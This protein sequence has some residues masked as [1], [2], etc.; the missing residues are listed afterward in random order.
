MSLV[1]A[2]NSGLTFV[3]DPIG[4]I[5][6]QLA[7]QQ[8]AALDARPHQKLPTTIFAQIRHWPLVIAIIAGVMISFVSSRKNRRRLPY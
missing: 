3:T 8:M 5:T 6:A 1:R 2:A 4:R 7:P